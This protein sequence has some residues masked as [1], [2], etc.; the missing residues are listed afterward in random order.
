MEDGADEQPSPYTHQRQP[1]E[2]PWYTQFKVPDLHVDEL[3]CLLDAGMR[4]QL[5]LCVLAVRFVKVESD[6]P[7]VDDGLLWSHDNKVSHITQLLSSESTWS[8]STRKG[9]VGL[10]L[11]GFRPSSSYFFPTATKPSPSVLSG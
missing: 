5:P 9:T 6:V 3:A 11:T 8:P 2:V 7:A 1:K 4:E 10:V